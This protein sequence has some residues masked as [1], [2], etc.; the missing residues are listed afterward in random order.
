LLW[1]KC[2]RLPQVV[3][4]GKQCRMHSCIGMLQLARS[5]PSKCPFPWGTWTPV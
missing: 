3:V 4:A 5:P 1:R 2:I